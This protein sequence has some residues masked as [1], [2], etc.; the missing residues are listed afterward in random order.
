MA[1]ARAMGMY[2]VK[3]VSVSA[4][5]KHTVVCTTKGEVFSFGGGEALG[6]SGDR[7]AEEV[8]PR[9]IKVLV[10][11]KV[12]GAATSDTHTAAWM[13]EGELFTFGSGL[14]GRLGHGGSENEDVPRLVEG[15]VGKKVIGAAAGLRHTAVWTEEGE[16]FTFG[17]GD[18]GHLV[19]GGTSTECAPRLLEV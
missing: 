8:T 11:K 16:L 6:H 1:A 12:I 7:Y 2:D 13:E 17:C 18:D 15:L 9:L 10:G 3:V 14:Y 4:G 19:H 5:P